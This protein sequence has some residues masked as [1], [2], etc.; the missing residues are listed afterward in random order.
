MEEELNETDEE[1]VI[2]LKTGL[3]GP[4]AG[5]GDTLFYCYLPCCGLFNGGLLSSSRTSC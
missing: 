4:F 3:M 2:G 1:A 5:V